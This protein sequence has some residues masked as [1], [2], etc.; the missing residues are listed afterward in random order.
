MN[1][2]LPDLWFMCIMEMIVL[3]NDSLLGYS[4]R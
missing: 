3:T 1:Q 4:G 2:S